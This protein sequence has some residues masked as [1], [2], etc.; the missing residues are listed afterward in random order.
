MNL[1]RLCSNRTHLRLRCLPL[2]D[3]RGRDMAV[4]IAKLTWVIAGDGS[5]SIAPSQSHVRLFDV[6]VT[7]DDPWSSV[8][9]PSDIVGEKPGTD[10]LLVGDAYPPAERGATAQ[11]VSLRIEAGD[12]TV[13]KSVRVHGERVFV[14][15]MLGVAPGPAAPLKQPVPLIY[16]RSFGGRDESDPAA[17]LV[18][19]RNPAGTGVA[20]DRER[21]V[22][23]RV[24]EIEDPRAPMGSRSPV[25]AGFGP[26]PTHWAP[27]A[28]RYGT[29]DARWQK[30]RAPVAPID[31]DP[32]HNCCAPDDLHC[33]SPLRGDEPVEI[34][35][36]V[37]EGIFRFQLPRYAPVFKAVIRGLVSDL[38][39]H[40]DTFLIDLSDPSARRV[41]LVWRASVPIPRK[42]EHLEKIYLL[43][44]GEPLPVA[45]ADEDPGLEEWLEEM[46]ARASDG[47]VMEERS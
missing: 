44:E 2:D 22:G 15:S 35:G 16:E 41:E 19:P 9:Y 24:P 33:A 14:K 32:R 31:F 29:P 4:V 23:T 13:Q 39:T 26:I 38:S 36:A 37:P 17:I 18:E 43:D 25:P 10:V 5:A 40:L 27:R 21:L 7:P 46:S 12:R 34:R 30:E 20:R 42:S 45:P 8:R 1:Q 6:P 47:P 28:A 11:E 3:H